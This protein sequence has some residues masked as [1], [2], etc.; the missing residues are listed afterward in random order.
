MKKLLQLLLGM[1]IAIPMSAQVN[2]QGDVLQSVA[3]D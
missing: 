1:T 3:T 2:G